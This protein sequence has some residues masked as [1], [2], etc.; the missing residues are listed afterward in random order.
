MTARIYKPSKAATQSGHAGTKRWLLVFE[1]ASPREIDVLMGW[2]SS[3]D[4]RQQLRLWFQTREEAEAY[5]KRQGIP[6]TV[7]E[8]KQLTRRVLSYSD[9]FKTNRTAPWTH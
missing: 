4:T 9:N 8:P 2:T 7:E 5:A 3:A 1:P 6:F